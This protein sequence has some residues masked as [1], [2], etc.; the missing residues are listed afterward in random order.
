MKGARDGWSWAREVWREGVEVAKEV[1]VILIKSGI[2]Q[3]KLEV[4]IFNYSRLV[5]RPTKMIN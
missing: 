5:L 4:E 2:L 1:A 3:E